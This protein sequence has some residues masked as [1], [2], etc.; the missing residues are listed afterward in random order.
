MLIPPRAHSGARLLGR[1]LL[2][3]ALSLAG[4]L[5]AAQAGTVD[6]TS[7]ESRVIKDAAGRAI[8]YY[9]SRAKAAGA[10]LMLMIQGSGCA[11]VFSSQAGGASSSI[12]NLAQFGAEGRFTVIAVEKPFSDITPAQG[13]AQPCSAAF[14]AD[15]TADSWARA[16]HAAL[17]DV[18]KTPGVS[19]TRTLVVGGSEGA[20]MAS[21]LAA[22]D[23]A[24]TDVVFI[25]GSGTT[26]LF[27]FIAQAYRSCFDAAQCLKTIETTVAAVRKKP[28]SATDFAWGH[29]FKRW[30]SF[31]ALDP[32]QLLL[33]SRA[34]VYI[35]LGT[36]DSSVPAVAQEVAVA[37]LLVA[38][39]DV[40]VRRV[41]D[42]DHSLRPAGA[43][44]MNDLDR[45]LRTALDWFWNG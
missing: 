13:S 19:A 1:L 17:A 22:R 2:A 35:A 25:S 40:T 37:K 8:T 32:G 9:I 41:A 44:H 12:F 36:A 24:I 21:L 28:G 45:E 42:G 4:A 39:R 15:F 10:P 27:D 38:G 5:A 16:L 34:R 7:F 30:T 3:C 31:F 43:T 18:R 26:Q 6:G 23:P 29:P 33:E 11:R 14:H 20:V